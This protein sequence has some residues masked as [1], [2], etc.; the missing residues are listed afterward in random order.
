MTQI[1]FDYVEEKQLMVWKTKINLYC[2][3]SVTV[4]R[5]KG[6]WW[7]DIMTRIHLR[8]PF[9]LGSVEFTLTMTR[10]NSP[11]LAA[12]GPPSAPALHSSSPC[13]S[14][15]SLL[16]FPSSTRAPRLL[17]LHQGNARPNENQKAFPKPQTALWLTQS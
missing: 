6:S 15:P 7:W 16:W 11:S 8:N 14:C 9:R 1:L 5:N 12:R 3:M 2:Q 13:A 4:T 17:L 10:R